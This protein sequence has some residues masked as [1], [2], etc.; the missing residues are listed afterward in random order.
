ML[1]RQSG[2]LEP[3]ELPE[4]AYADDG[5]A[6]RPVCGALPRS[7]VLTCRVTLLRRWGAAAIVLRLYEDG[8]GYTDYPLTFTDTDYLRDT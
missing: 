4:I 5:G 7:T 8:G 1:P 3:E 6:F 2:A